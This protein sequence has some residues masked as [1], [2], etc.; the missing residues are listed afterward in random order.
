MSERQS[1]FTPLNEVS[2]DRINT[3][4]SLPFGLSEKVGINTRFIQA[5]LQIGGIRQLNIIGDWDGKTSQVVPTI[6]AMD[7]RGSALAGRVEINQAPVQDYEV[8]SNKKKSFSQS[9][10][11]DLDLKLNLAEIQR[12][13]RDKDCDVREPIAWAKEIDKALRQ[14]I[15]S[16]GMDNLLHNLS[17]YDKFISLFMYV[18]LFLIAAEASPIHLMLDKFNPHAPSFGVIFSYFLSAGIPL[19]IFESFYGVE[20]S[21]EGRRISLVIGPELDRALV[22]GIAGNFGRLAGE[23]D[24]K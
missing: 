4:V 13:I 12:I 5:L 18:G 3:L 17:T 15:I 2:T 20:R 23:A 11:T 22:L 21:G 9:K 7:S 16:A 14:G 19:T 6:V 24:A 10:W 1:K 8:E